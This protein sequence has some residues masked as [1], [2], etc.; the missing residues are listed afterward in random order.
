[1]TRLNAVQLILLIVGLSALGGCIFFGMEVTPRYLE[2]YYVGHERY[3]V[4][5][6]YDAG[7]DGAAIGLG[8][9]GGICFACTVWIE[10]V[11]FKAKNRS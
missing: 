6:N 7:Y 5:P 9:V 2:A 8:F 4:A 10:I 11:R 1:M 3:G